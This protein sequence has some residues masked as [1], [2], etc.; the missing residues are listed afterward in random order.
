VFI[1]DAGHSRGLFLAGF[2]AG[3]AAPHLDLNPGR[4]GRQLA[5]FTPGSRCGWRPHLVPRGE[6]DPGKGGDTT[7][8]DV[9]G[10]MA[11]VALLVDVREG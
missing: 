3:K 6:T 11:T 1:H 2:Q 8:H 10:P 7:N 4:P 9:L 5:A